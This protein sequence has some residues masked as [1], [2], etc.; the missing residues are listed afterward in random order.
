MGVSVTTGSVETL[1]N[2][3]GK[4]AFAAAIETMTQERNLGL[5]CIVSIE[6]DNEGRLKKGIMV[7]RSTS[8][9]AQL[10][11]K[12]DG[13]LAL[14]EGT[15]DMQLSN[16]RQVDFERSG[17]HATYYNI[18]NIRYSRKAYEAIVKNNEF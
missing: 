15:A 1:I 13:L 4:D 5:F 18:G 17:N 6:N 3:F 2:Y 8:S 9:T 11:G 7:H 10:T 12:Y 14:I 16:K